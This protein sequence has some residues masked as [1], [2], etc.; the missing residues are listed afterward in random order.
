MK[1]YPFLFSATFRFVLIFILYSGQ[2]KLAGLKLPPV[3]CAVQLSFLFS[4]VPPY[5]TKWQANTDKTQLAS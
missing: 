2:E 5:L 4:S 1:A 3:I